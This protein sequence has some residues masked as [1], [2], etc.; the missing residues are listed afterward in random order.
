MFPNTFV[1]IIPRDEASTAFVAKN[2]TSKNLIPADIYVGP[3]IIH[4]TILSPDNS[5]SILR[6]YFNFGV[7]DAVIDCQ[8]PDT[9]LQGLKAPFVMVR[10]HL[11]QGIAMRA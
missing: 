2:N 7:R 5:F 10:T 9:K 8:L 4:G 3:Y 1:A 6:Y 11:L